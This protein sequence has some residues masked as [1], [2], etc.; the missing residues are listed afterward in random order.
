MPA[1]VYYGRAWIRTAHGWV[2]RPAD[3]S[4]ETASDE[5]PSSVSRFV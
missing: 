2:L 3:A 1:T 5:R 4:N